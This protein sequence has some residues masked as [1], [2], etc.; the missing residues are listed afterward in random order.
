MC[1]NVSGYNEKVWLCK[2]QSEWLLIEQEA[3]MF[4]LKP[5]TVLWICVRFSSW[6]LFSAG[7]QAILY[8][9][10]YEYRHRNSQKRRNWESDKEKGRYWDQ[11][12]CQE[13]KQKVREVMSFQAGAPKSAAPAAGGGD[14]W[15][16]IRDWIRKAVCVCVCRW[17][18]VPTLSHMLYWSLVE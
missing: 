1:V 18:L 2:R 15:N 8:V 7:R 6:D 16:W 11:E 12:E 10:A 4:G 13:E 14:I 5:D 17:T 3:E 9:A